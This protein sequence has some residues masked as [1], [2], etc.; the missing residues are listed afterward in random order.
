MVLKQN[1]Q[2]LYFTQKE[3]SLYAFYEKDNEEKTAYLKIADLKLDKEIL[4]ITDMKSKQELSVSENR[5]IVDVSDE[6]I[7]GIKIELQS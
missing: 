4:K 5:I 7:S 1:I 6:I 2:H 3:Q